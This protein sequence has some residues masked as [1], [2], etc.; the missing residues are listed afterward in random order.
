M[1]P[2]LLR[3]LR[4]AQWVKNVFVLAPV[5]FGF[6]LFDP[7]ALGR[8]L[9]AA[10][11]FCLASGGVYV[12]NDLMDRESDRN[13]PLKRD[14]PLASG[15]VPVPAALVLLGACAAGGLGAAWALSPRCAGILSAYLALNL[16]YSLRLKH[17]AVLDIFCVAL[18]FLLRVLM[19]GAAS[20]VPVSQWILVMT[21]LTALFLGLAKRRDDVL[22][23]RNG[24]AVRRAVDGYNLRFVETAMTVCAAVLL[25][26]Y[27]MY[28]LSPAVGARLGTRRVYLTF[29][30]VILGVLRYFQVT[31]VFEESGS[32]TRVLFR[33]RFLQAALLGWLALFLLLLYG[34]AWLK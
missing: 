34:P 18:G 1:L 14:R 21:F 17:L 33:D 27:L 9:L 16:A 29:L 3:L 26:A 32:P 24:A 5:V 25:V 10:L 6:R 2:P 11:A 7:A 31:L 30:F 13:H 22:L 4:P 20:A 28:A 12:L 8:S 23:A 19:G 15:A